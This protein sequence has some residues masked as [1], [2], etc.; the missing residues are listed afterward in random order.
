[1]QDLALNF[2]PND[3]RRYTATVP[4]DGD[5]VLLVSARYDKTL[6][7]F[8]AHA[9]FGVDHGTYVQT[10]HR[11]Y[12]G[13]TNSEL[14]AVRVV[15]RFNAAA[16]IAWIDEMS[17]PGSEA[18]TRSADLIAERAELAELAELAEIAELA[19]LAELAGT[20]EDV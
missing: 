1:M 12:G 19:E 7:Q 15:Y 10:L 20:P 17:A 18:S 6:R 2:V 4:L 3:A 5:N 16:F 9:S 14:V 8:R 13:P 11:V